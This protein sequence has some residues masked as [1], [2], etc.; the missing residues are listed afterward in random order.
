MCSSLFKGC[1]V[2]MTF[3]NFLSRFYTATKQGV[4]FA[5]TWLRLRHY[6]TLL[7]LSKHDLDCESRHLALQ[8]LKRKKQR[9][10]TRTLK[11]WKRILESPPCMHICLLVVG[12]YLEK[13]NI[14]IPFVWDVIESLKIWFTC[15]I[16]V[17]QQELSLKLKAIS[18]LG[19]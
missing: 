12:F 18:N 6:S 5:Q 10:K 2:V 13:N 1:I 19:F 15:Y 7:C 14:I 17:Y 8:K 16:L 4:N 11:F 3:E 9:E